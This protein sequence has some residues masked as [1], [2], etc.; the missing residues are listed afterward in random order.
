MISGLVQR[1]KSTRRKLDVL[2]WSR[3]LLWCNHGL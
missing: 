1:R 2:E 3:F